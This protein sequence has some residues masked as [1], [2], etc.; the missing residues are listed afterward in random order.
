MQPGPRPWHR[1]PPAECFLHYGHLVRGLQVSE[2]KFT[3]RQLWPGRKA[4]APMSGS[5]CHNDDGP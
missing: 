4:W 2:F 1:L 5:R 3:Q